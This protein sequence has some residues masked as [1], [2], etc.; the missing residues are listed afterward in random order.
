MLRLTDFVI[1]CPDTMELAGFYSEVTGRPLE[2]HSSA[3]WAGIQFG[4]IE[5]AFIRVDDHRAPQWPDTEHRNK[6]VVR[7]G[8]GPVRPGRD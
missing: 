4:E 5:L 8:Q 6:G 3:D 7:T 1:D 2:K